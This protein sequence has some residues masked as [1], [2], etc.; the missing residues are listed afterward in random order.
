[1]KVLCYKRV[2]GLE[3]VLRGNEEERGT[4]ILGEVAPICTVLTAKTRV[5]KFRLSILLLD[6]WT[7]HCKMALE[8]LTIL[9]ISQ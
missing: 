7:I 2:A 4:R 3:N 1:M 8:H 9:E 6:C 5:K